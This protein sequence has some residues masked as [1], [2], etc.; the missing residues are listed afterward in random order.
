[1]VEA[2]RTSRKALSHYYDY[3]GVSGG[4]N[5]T[6]QNP[7]PGAQ[8][9]AQLG[10]FIKTNAWGHHASCSVPIGAASDPMA[11]LDSKFRYVFGAV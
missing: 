1:M 3:S 10:D 11:A 8:T 5:F 7:G 9:D 2:I 4:S 6:E